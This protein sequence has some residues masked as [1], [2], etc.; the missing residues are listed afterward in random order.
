M[1]TVFVFIEQKQIHV[2][3]DE[4]QGFGALEMFGKPRGK[5]RSSSFREINRFDYYKRDIQFGDRAHRIVDGY[6]ATR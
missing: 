5:P 3:D 2:T 1:A 6:A 4:I